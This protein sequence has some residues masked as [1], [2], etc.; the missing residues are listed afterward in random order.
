[1]N[2]DWKYVQQ[3]VTNEGVNSNYRPDQIGAGQMAW[4][5]N[6]TIREGKPRTRSYKFI[7]RA[8]LPKGLVQGGGYFSRDG[9]R[10]ILSIW[11]Q[12][13]RV[14]VN[15]NNVVIDS[16]PLAFR[17]SST[18]KQAWMCETA[19]SFLVQDGESDCIIFDGSTTRRANPAINEVPLGRQMAY[20][21]GRLAVAVNQSQVK[22]G[23]ITTDTFQS[24]L[25]FTETNYLNGGG[26]FLF[27]YNVT[28][29]AFLP[30]NNTFSGYGSL[31]VFGNQF[32]NSLHLEITSRDLWDKKDGFEVVVVP[33]GA[34]G[35]GTV[36]KVNQ[37]IYFRDAKGEIWSVRSAVSDAGSPGNSPL[38][39][40]VSRVVDF[41]T[42]QLVKYSSA[43]YFDNR[44]MFLASP[45][46]NEFGAASYKNIISLDAATLASM[47][48]KQPPAYDGVA[49]GLNFVQLMS[50]RVNGIDRA[51]AISTDDD[52]E[53][54]LWEIIPNGHAD[55][56]LA[57]VDGSLLLTDVPVGSQVESRR[58]VFGDTLHQMMRL[59]LWPAEIAGEV[60][61]T[62]YWRADNRTKWQF[63]DTFDM[64]ATMEN[65]DDQWL[66]LDSQE[67]GRVKSLSAPSVN[68]D[69]DNQQADVGFGFQV[70][71]VWTGQMLMDRMVLWARPLD[72]GAYSNIPDLE[73]TCVKNS[74]AN[75]DSD[76]TIPVGGLG[77]AYTDQD[78]NVYV[79]SFG[80]P[81]TQQI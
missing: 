7:Q 34:C 51:F 23:D 76:Y 78:Q 35:Q 36:I 52:G 25:N 9:G 10:F 69:I 64:C 75:N 20:G 67:R 61:V 66:T 37:D 72:E 12:L 39:R 1:M 3:V 30:V 33:I 41:E 63:W 55:G 47:R 2:K 44:L 53:N 71:L 38:S 40:E 45:I 18:N 54:R 11:G 56:Y 59:D 80:I 8:I 74:V 4:A 79:D 29:L 46:V 5:K 65:V 19:G 58:F 68:D 73:T 42:E 22:V 13:W 81:Y 48:G 26:S 62:A 27:P 31:L 14:T 50:G 15:A 28:A 77:S 24:E 6:V 49:E 70:K 43:I 17:N 57:D 21:N 60:T 16:I 32:L